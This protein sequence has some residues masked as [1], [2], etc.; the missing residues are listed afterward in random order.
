MKFECGD[1]LWLKT[2]YATCIGNNAVVMVKFPLVVELVEEDRV[3][4]NDGV[5]SVAIALN[6]PQL[7][8]I[9][10]M[11]MAHNG[12]LSFWFAG[13]TMKEMMEYISP[14]MGY[15]MDGSV[16]F[17]VDQGGSGGMVG[18]SRFG[19]SDAEGF[20]DTKLIQEL[21]QKDASRALRE[22]IVI[23]PPRAR[24]WSQITSWCKRNI[25]CGGR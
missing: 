3:I 14:Y 19:D 4:A 11:R 21:A 2:R 8:I 6:K 15:K 16:F 20:A 5:R 13:L 10:R 22:A 7:D 25:L 12:R 18:W 17:C 9:G 24:W 23:I 1:K